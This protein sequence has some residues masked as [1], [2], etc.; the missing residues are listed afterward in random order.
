MVQYP[1]KAGF[2]GRVTRWEILKTFPDA[3]KE[4]IGGD[5]SRLEC[6]EEPLD[7][8]SMGGVLSG[9]SE[10]RDRHG[11]AW[12]RLMFC[13]MTG[14]ILVLHCFQKKTN[15]TK[16]RD[17]ETTRQRL[18]VVNETI[19]IRKKRKNM[20]KNKRDVLDDLGFSP[21]QTALLRE[22]V[23]LQTAIVKRAKGYSQ[24]QIA[25]IL[26]EHQPRVSDLMTGKVS[27]FTLDTLFLY[28]E[29]LKNVKSAMKREA[30]HA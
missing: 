19:A 16:Q 21:E 29:K 25:E 8:K 14:L 5:L 11:R 4:N 24:A 10:L 3:V 27:K 12:Y 22:K 2:G 7:F 15:Q 23:Q 20:A 28:L 18:K 13:S 1:H 26:D 17:I 6:G 9:V 30:I